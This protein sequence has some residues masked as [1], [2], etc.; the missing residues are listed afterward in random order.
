MANVALE[1]GSNF[2]RHARQWCSLGATGH[3]MDGVFGHYSFFIIRE[4]FAK[5]GLGDKTRACSLCEFGLGFWVERDW[6]CGPC[7]WV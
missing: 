4:W 6:G 5:Q 3:A 2:G 1:L 7:Y